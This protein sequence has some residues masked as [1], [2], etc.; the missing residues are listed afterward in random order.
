MDEKWTIDLEDSY[1]HFSLP[2][3]RDQSEC[4]NVS[5][6]KAQFLAESECTNISHGK[7]QFLAERNLELT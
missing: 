7:A 3:T 6:G 4:T 5:H 1:F 2:W